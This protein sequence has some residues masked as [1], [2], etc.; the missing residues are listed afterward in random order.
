MSLIAHV[1]ATQPAPSDA[2][3]ELAFKQNSV[4]MIY[5]KEGTGSLGNL[6]LG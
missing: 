6:L 1:S 4:V 5:R 2:L 3:L